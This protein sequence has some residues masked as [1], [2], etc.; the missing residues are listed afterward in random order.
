[1]MSVASKGDGKVELETI[2]MMLILSCYPSHYE[3]R[4]EMFIIFLKDDMSNVCIP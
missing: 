4:K 2:A 1:M 3:N